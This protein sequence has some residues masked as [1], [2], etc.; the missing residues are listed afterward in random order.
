M[1]AGRRGLQPGEQAGEAPARPRPG[2]PGPAPADLAFGHDPARARGCSP[3]PRWA[4]GAPPRP[5]HGGR[6]PAPDASKSRT[7]GTS[8][9][10]R[11]GRR[12]GPGAT[13]RP[14]GAGRT[15]RSRRGARAGSGGRRCPRRSGRAGSGRRRRARPHRA[16]ALRPTSWPVRPG[17]AA[18]SRA[19]A[20]LASAGSSGPPPASASALSSSRRASSVSTSGRELSLGGQD[21]HPVVGHGQ[22]PAA[23]RRAHRGPRRRPRTD[24]DQAA[25]GQ[26]AEHRRVPGQDADV[27]LGGLG[28]HDPGLAG[29]QL[30]IRHDQRYLQRHRSSSLAFF[31][32]SSI[33]PT[34]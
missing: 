1:G 22:E 20:Y 4:G 12:R 29:P 16:P 13:T 21:R 9:S 23:D 34:M 5:G 2:Q 18:R 19:L 14:A 11:P 3:R 10:H 30:A 7:R 33:P 15:R 25:L 24:L 31:S 27:A 8:R 26:D 6:R 32:T 17:R 28:D